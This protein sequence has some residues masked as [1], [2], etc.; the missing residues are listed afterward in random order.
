MTTLKKRL[1]FTQNLTDTQFYEALASHTP[2]LFHYKKNINEAGITII[3]FDPITH[4]A[5]QNDQF[6]V[7]GQ[8]IISKDPL[9]TL[10]RYTYT[11]EELFPDLDFQGG[12]I[13]YTSY[14]LA[15]FYEPITH[16]A[17][18]F[19]ELPDLQFYLYESFV[20]VDHHTN[21]QCIVTSNMYSHV[22]EAKL[23]LRLNEISEHLAHY[24]PTH[25]TTALTSEPFTSTLQ[26]NE[27]M[28]IVK[29]AKTYINDG[30]LFQVVPSQRL[31]APFTVE[32]LAYFEELAR[33]N[34][35]TYLYLLEFPDVTIIGSSPET[36]VQVSGNTVQTNPIAGTRRRGKNVL[37]DQELATDLL[38]DPKERAEHQMLVDLGRNDLSKISRIG[39]VRLP[40]FMQVKRYQHVMHLVSIV[41][42][43]LNENSTPI[44]A[45]KATLPAGT[46]SGAPKI[47]AMQR[48]YEFE[49]TK[50]GIYAGGIGFLTHDQ[51]LDMAIAIRTMLIKDH[52]AYVQAGAGIVHDSDPLMEYHETLNKA[53]TL[54]EV[55]V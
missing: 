46:V 11:T 51:R 4:L 28:T 26:S 2:C 8:Q 47:R 22:T 23:D 18:D 41:T 17:I 24:Q 44:A 36:L 29:Q 43:T 7:D 3:G 52:T 45:L 38:N 35:S 13:G 30:D 50:R 53:K 15:F 5:F 9:K 55:L 54:L 14:D 6:F 25:K 20:Y 33:Q 48:I 21:T 27:F 49:A 19:F 32:P 1:L 40:L 12:A 31:S 39:S 37:E 16:Q 42:A 10:E 34:P